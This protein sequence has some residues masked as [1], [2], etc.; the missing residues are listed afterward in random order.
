MRRLPFAALGAVLVAGSL[1]T[2]GALATASQ[3]ATPY[4]TNYQTT[5]KNSTCA[6]LSKH[7]SGAIRG[8]DGHA[9]NAYIGM[10]LNTTV[11]GALVRIDGGGCS[12]STSRAG[13]GY[14]ITVHVNYQLPSSG[15]D[16]SS[17]PD[18]ITTW[19][20]DVPS[21]TT[22]IY[23]E[24]TP[25]GMSSQ[26]KFGTTDQT[27]YGNSMRSN[28][29]ITQ[30]PQTISALNLPVN[31]CGTLSTG[32]IKGWIYQGGKRVK[33]SYVS[34]FSQIK[35]SGTPAGNGP[36]GFNNVTY[37]TPTDT[38]HLPKLASGG[39]KGQAYTIIARLSTG[40]SKQFYMLDAH[41][42]QHAGVLACKE[43]SFNLTF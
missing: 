43:V 5:N 25:K 24:V 39:G 41:G 33:V 37:S 6:P 42:I 29:S 17:N 18:A 38:F 26:P 22:V 12:G 19:N 23:F 16:P 31:K 10:D 14:G 2:V 7:I 35:G 15:V 3:A 34:A 4:P 30:N 32:G 1:A 21:N 9:V 8:Y 13:S 36:F 27:Y 20:A 11:N 40:Q 28:I